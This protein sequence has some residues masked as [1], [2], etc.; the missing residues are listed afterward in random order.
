VVLG[1]RQWRRQQETTR[2]S[3]FVIEKQS[4]YKGLW[5]K[6]E[7]VHIKVRTEEVSQAEF[8]VLLREV[9]SY[10]LRH[11]LYLNDEDQ[12]LSNEYLRM[13]FRFKEVLMN[14]VPPEAQEYFF[15]TVEALPQSLAHEATE[16]RS[17]GRETDRIRK[18]IIS[19]CR[20]VIAPKR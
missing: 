11:A 13:V 19:R 10:I 17:L 14:S 1:Y 6:L 20:D 9:N 2:F 12:V 7:D 18:S 4:A 3:T 16:L 8:N 5:E 15:L